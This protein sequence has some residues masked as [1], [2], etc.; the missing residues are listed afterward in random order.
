MA[1]LKSA[2]ILGDLSDSQASQRSKSPSKTREPVRRRK[3][4]AEAAGQGK[5]SPYHAE[6]RQKLRQKTQLNF[7]GIPQF[8]ADEFERLASDNHMG[9]REYLYHL[10]RQ[11]GAD[12]PPYKEMDG[13]KL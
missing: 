3:A 9:K 7:G 6:L 4:L 12:I 2:D 5:P 8:I 13:R 1:T 11:E 10:L